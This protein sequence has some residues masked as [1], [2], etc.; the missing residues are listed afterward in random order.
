[1]YDV[2]AVGHITRDRIRIGNEVRE[3][4]GGAAYYLSLALRRFGRNVAVVTKMARADESFLLSE[5]KAER[6]DIS[7]IESVTTTT[8][9]NVYSEPDLHRRVQK[10]GSVA[11]PFACSDLNGFRA[12]FF[13]LGP[14]TTR[15]MSL[16]FLREASAR[17]DV[18]LDVQGLVRDASGGE[19]RMDAWPE[20]EEGLA[21][22]TVL[23]ADEDEARILTGE[24]DPEQAAQRLAGWGPRE[25]IVTFGSRGSVIYSAGRLHRISPV[26]A[27][28]VDDATGCGDTYLAAYLHRRLK[29]GNLERAGR[30]A[31]AAATLTL[32]RFGSFHATERDVEDVARADTIRARE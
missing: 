14:L 10:A 32:G 29:S 11:A 16:D 19:I 24:T 4:P 12:R 27:S 30:F 23:K 18:S 1:M 15:D 9:E 25:V 31:S 22:V 28:K 13:H 21:C 17:G 8:F 20:M 2:C 26:P 3:Q 6:I 5:L 7:C